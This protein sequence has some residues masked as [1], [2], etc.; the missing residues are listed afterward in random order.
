LDEAA[1]FLQ[2]RRRDRD[3]EASADV[4]VHRR[5]QVEDLDRFLDRQV[6]DEDAAVL[7]GAHEPGLVEHAER[8]AQRSARDA[9]AGGERHLGELVAGAELARQDHAFELALDD[10]RE[11]ARLQERDGRVR[12][13]GRG[14]GWH[15]PSRN[16]ASPIVNN[17]QKTVDLAWATAETAPPSPRRTV[18][19]RT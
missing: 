16:H 19:E 9:E 13:G 4:L 12:R 11:R 10:A 5:A 8:L 17:L 7:L 3:G 1:H 18:T 15:R 14:D 6:A 2:R